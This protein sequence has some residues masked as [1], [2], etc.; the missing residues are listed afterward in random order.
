M[1]GRGWSA[2]AAGCAVLLCVVAAAG[3][4]AGVAGTVDTA[5]LAAT[6]ASEGGSDGAAAVARV[7]PDADRGGAAGDDRS[8]L[9]FVSTGTSDVR[10]EVVVDGVAW[11]T[12]ADGNAADRADTVRYTD[13]G[14]V[15][16]AGTA[17]VGGG[18]AFVVDGEVVE[19]RL[20]DPD[21]DYRI[22]LDDADVTDGVPTVVDADEGDGRTDA[23]ESGSADDTDQGAGGETDDDGQSDTAAP[24]GPDDGGQ[25]GIDTPDAADGTGDGTD[26]A[27]GSASDGADDT[28]SPE[29]T[30]AAGAER[31]DSCTVIDEP[32]RY[33]VGDDI[34][35][36]GESVCLHVRASDVVLDGGGNTVSGAGAEGSVGVLVL[37][38]TLDARE[39]GDP[40]SNVTVRNLRV[41]GW[42]TGIQAGSGDATGT[43]LTLANVDAS[44][45][46]RTGVY[47]DE[48]DDST[49]RDVTASDNR[50]GVLLRETYDIAVDGLV[51]ADN[52]RHGLYLAQ[53]V[54]DSTFTDVR[55]VGNGDGESAGI[56]LSTD[57]ENTVIADSVVADNDG[58]GIALSDTYQNTVRDTTIED[59]AGPGVLG[60]FPSDDRVENVTLR[61]NADSQLR[62]ESGDLGAT[63]VT[64]GGGVTLGADGG[65][66]A[67][68]GG[69]AVAV[70]TVGTDDLPGDPPGTPAARAALTTDGPPVEAAVG[71]RLDDA[72]DADA[73]ELWRYDGGWSRVADGTAED[74]VLRATVQ[75]GG[76]IVPLV[77]DDT[78]RS[79][80]TATPE[81]E[82]TN[83][84]GTTGTP[85]DEGTGTPTDEETGTP[86][87]TKTPT[88]EETSTSES[89]GTPTDEGTSTPG[90]TGTP[91]DG[92]TEAPERVVAPDKRTGG[93]R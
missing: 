87:T 48:V 37:N 54:G 11:G 14:R 32:G 64:L 51:A 93:V 83:T 27:T 56:R 16:V 42:D 26:D 8:T 89:T 4:A 85:T 57:V 29:G 55:A 52:A 84:P 20:S 46:T 41:T 60:S 39:V 75:T 7:R 21:A 3:M 67:P 38:G 40:L 68:F 47:F 62:L 50:F 18:D 5:G 70:D 91:T 88:D 24:N 28:A 13:D 63:G 61:G 22:E 45:N 82:E 31:I 17:A 58:P 49:V 36:S 78:E 74:G 44:G 69:D 59:N 90:T 77:V 33:E 25:S 34:D 73:V 79:E 53:N 65:V 81:G 66:S 2:G 30:T 12:A 19:V 43:S 1:T 71:F 15:V 92:D 35:A 9:E 6:T 72:V 80:E 10:Y 76:V 23:D 86:E